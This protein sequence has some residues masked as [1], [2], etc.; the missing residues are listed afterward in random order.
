MLPAT[1]GRKEMPLIQIHNNKINALEISLANKLPH[2]L[3]NNTSHSPNEGE[4][5]GSRFLLPSVPVKRG[6]VV[7][8]EWQAELSV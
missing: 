3:R 5:M 6:L 1:V 4:L 7:E 2:P 8:Q